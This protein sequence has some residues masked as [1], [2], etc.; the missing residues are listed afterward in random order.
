MEDKKQSDSTERY[1][2][3]EE[4]DVSDKLFLYYRYPD[5]DNVKVMYPKTLTA[6]SDGHTIIDS[7]GT[8]HFAPNGFI[9]LKSKPKE[10]AQDSERLDERV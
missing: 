5:R 2:L 1:P 8:E 4:Q 3:G 6:F 7:Y 9:H 10:G